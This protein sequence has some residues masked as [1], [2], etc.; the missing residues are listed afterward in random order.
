MELTEYKPVLIQ[1][2]I[3]GLRPGETVL[4]TEPRPNRE[5]KEWKE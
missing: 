4:R 2:V 1:D 3:D 5:P